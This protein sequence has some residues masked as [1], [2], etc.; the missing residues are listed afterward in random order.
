MW[1]FR[2]HGGSIYHFNA[3][4]NKY[5]VFLINVVLKMLSRIVP[6]KT[7]LLFALVEICRRS[8]TDNNDG[9]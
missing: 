4:V 7:T 2:I 3:A 9:K 5:V 8:I 6:L 1:Y